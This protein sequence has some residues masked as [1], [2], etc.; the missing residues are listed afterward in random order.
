MNII[1]PQGLKAIDD[2][3]IN[4]TGLL[5]F[6]SILVEFVN[7]V[8]Q[9]I[10][11]DTI[12]QTLPEMVTL[13]FWMRKGHIHQLQDKFFQQN[14]DK[15]LLPRGVVFHL[16]P[17]NVDTIFVY[18]WFLSL[19]VGNG[20]ILRIS[21]NSNKQ[22]V[23]LLSIISTV[24]A[25]SK[26]DIILS[27]N[28]IIQYAHNSDITKKLSLLADTRV[29][30]GGDKT[31]EKIRTFPIKATATE[32]TFADKF[33]F[34]IIKSSTLINNDEIDEFI[35]SF[36]NDAFWFGQR[37][38]SSIRLI[39]WV[40]TTSEISRAQLILWG[41]LEER[42]RI[43]RPDVIEV[44]D[45]VNKL[46]VECSLAIEENIH[47]LKT[48]SPYINRIKLTNLKNINDDL[49]CGGG[50]FYEVEALS[51]LDVF[52]NITKKI[53][54]ISYYGFSD[55]QLKDALFETQPVGIDRI[56]PIGKSLEFSH[57]WDGYDL[58]QDFCRQIEICS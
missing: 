21:D 37:A 1:S 24:L 29:I 49:H 40:G 44:A 7:D 31:I 39:A 2:I 20:N 18:S 19:L 10:L 42:I 56:V 36:Y 43:K 12:A 32:L 51:L 38:C 26:Y 3:E 4:K 45:I 47:I 13:A 17:S 15:Q 30:W 28:F 27:S 34:A 50:L 53:Q 9:E 22:V 5:P 55:K 8:S 11:N 48:N 58:L 33:S 41:K 25:K 54:T 16:P 35:T 6:S 14:K 23:D 52:S 46:V 57:I